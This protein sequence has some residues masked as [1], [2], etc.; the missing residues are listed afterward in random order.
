MKTKTNEKK[1]YLY[2][3]V[4]DALSDYSRDIYYFDPVW[5]KKQ[6]KQRSYVQVY[7]VLNNDG[8]VWINAWHFNDIVG[9]GF[10]L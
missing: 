2:E 5:V 1:L 4:E 3:K 9:R 6:F 10:I 7:E 8:P